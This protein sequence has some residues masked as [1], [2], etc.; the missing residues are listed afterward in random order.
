MSMPETSSEDY[1]RR[2]RAAR[3]FKGIAMAD[4]AAA[5]GFSV[6]TLARLEVGARPLSVAEARVIAQATG[7]PLAFLIDGWPSAE[8]EA[9]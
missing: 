7:V 8:Q 6:G 1:G 5:A 2:V 3:A 9:A 4:L